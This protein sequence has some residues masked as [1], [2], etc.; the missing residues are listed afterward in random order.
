MRKN[1]FHTY[2]TVLGS[3]VMSSLILWPDSAMARDINPD[4]ASNDAFAS[5]LKL[6]AVMGGIAVVGWKYLNSESAVRSSRPANRNADVSPVSPPEILNPL[7]VPSDEHCLTRDSA[8]KG[9]G[10]TESGGRKLFLD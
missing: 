7:Q 10:S 2:A 5:L 6:V 4:R 8:A 9:N 1:A 3:V